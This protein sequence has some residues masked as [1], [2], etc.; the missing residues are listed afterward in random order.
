MRMN[1]INRRSGFTLV[2]LL[3]SIVIIGMLMSLTS[4]AVWN[5]LKTARSSKIAVEVDHL[6]QAMQS[7]KEAQ[8]AFPPA[9]SEISLT[10]RKLNFMRHLQLAYANSAYGVTVTSFANITNSILLAQSGTNTV[11]WGY[12]YLSNGSIQP[13]D[14]RT[15]DQA[16]SLVFWLGGFPTP[17][18]SSTQ[19]PVATRRLFGFHRD[20]DN[21]LKRD[22]AAFEQTDPLRYRTDPLFG[23]DDTRLVDNDHDGWLEYTPLPPKLGVPTAPYVYFDNKTYNNSINNATILHYGYP[24]YD[25][26]GSASSEAANLYSQWGVAAPMATFFDPASGNN[27]KPTIWAKPDGF[28]IICAGLDGQYSKPGSNLLDSQRVAVFPG[29]YVFQNETNYN[30]QTAYTTPEYDNITNLSSRT[31]EGARSEGQQ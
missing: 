26:D 24:R 30:T 3:V 12:N 8:I 13:L 1:S 15:L 27:R 5:T 20:T 28:Q 23:F 11:R 22:P 6:S 9:M 19:A 16:E 29:G 10:N 2:E 17:I 4:V 25:N 31:L 18:N 21:P 7:Y 14:L